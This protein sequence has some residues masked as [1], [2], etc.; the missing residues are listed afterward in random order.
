MPEGS[1]AATLVRELGRL[2][3]RRMFGVPGGGSSLDLIQAGADQGVD[4]VLA[5]TETAAAIM[6][7]ATAELTG[8]PGVVL[9]GL[10]PG[11]A[12]VTNGLA[13]ARLDRAPLVVITDAYP[14]AYRAFVTHQRFDHAALFAPLVKGSLAPTGATAPGRL[15][16]LL[17]AALQP[18]RGPVHVDLSSA[19]AGATMA[20]GEPIERAPTPAG[21]WQ[22]EHARALLAAAERPALLVGLEARAAADA[23]RALAAEL[24]GPALTSWKARA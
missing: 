24:R 9:T 15:R 16:A 19:A 7:A 4:F 23:T 12:G 13:Q 8:A 1:V 10:G 6:A 17:E 20:A 21:P 2:G 11:A 3:V 14:P 5:R 22:V 18:P